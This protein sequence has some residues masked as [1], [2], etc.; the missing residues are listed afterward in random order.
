MDRDFIDIDY[1]DIKNMFEENKKAFISNEK[2]SK[3]LRNKRPNSIPE[4]LCYYNNLLSYA[5][6]VMISY[7]HGTLIKEGNKNAYYRGEKKV[8]PTNKSSLLRKLEDFHTEKEKETYKL[9][10][11]MRIYEFENFINQFEYI[12]EWYKQVGT[13]ILYEALA[14]HYG[15][16]TYYLD[17]TTNFMTALF[18]ATC[19]F[20]YTLNEWRPLTKEEIKENEYGIIYRNKN[21]SVDFLNNIKIGE[22]DKSAILPIGKQPFMR[23]EYQSAYTIKSEEGIDLRKINFEKLRFKHSEELSER[24][25][26]YMDKGKKIYPDEG[27]EAFQD[28]IKT[29]SKLTVFSY[30]SFEYALKRSSYFNDIETAIEAI[31]TFKYF[32]IKVLEKDNFMKVSRQRRRNFDRKYEKN[33]CK[34]KEIFIPYVYIP[35]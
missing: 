24:V 17:I 34:Y 32:P 30:S 3:N 7:P 5:N 15:L 27:I 11:Y 26:L 18:F 35:E 8:Y 14:Q 13:T 1:K 25:Y 4:F 19:T 2:I 16:E 12:S 33:I 29:I 21:D 10:A 22:N 9:V 23:C 28:E 6:D 20:D 31:K